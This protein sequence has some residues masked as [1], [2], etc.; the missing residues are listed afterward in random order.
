MPEYIDANGLLIPSLEEIREAIGAEQRAAIDPLL[1][2]DMDSAL[3]IMNAIVATKIREALEVGEVGVWGID[4]RDAEGAALDRVSRITGTTR[5]A[6]TRST[7]VLDCGVNGGTVLPAL[8]TRARVTGS[9]PQSVW[10]L[11]ATHTQAP[12]PPSTVSLVF[13]SEN[14]GPVPANAGTITTIHTPIA[15]WTSVNNPADAT[16][17]REVEADPDLRV[18]RIV[19]LFRPGEVTPPATLANFLADARI[20]S[21]RY[22]ENTTDTIDLATGLAPHSWRVIVWDGVAAPIPTADLDAIVEASRQ[23]GI[24][25][26]WVRATATPFEVQVYGYRGPD[27]DPDAVKA[28]IVARYQREQTPGSAVLFASASAAALSAGI[29]S[30]V[31]VRLRFPAGVFTQANLT[32][33]ALNVGTVDTSAITLFVTPPP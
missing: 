26:S 10:R 29:A 33:G 1:A 31:E 9:D 8:T 22:Q 18:R 24:D 20:L 32:I 19:D 13:E 11:V 25:G 3:G 12:G 23:G 6:P 30:V 4:P 15:G 21:A 16:L 14:L 2:N 17:G 7:V 27:Y 5:R 28:A